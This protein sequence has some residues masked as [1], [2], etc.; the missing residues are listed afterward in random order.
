MRLYRTLLTNGASAAGPG[1][2]LTGHSFPARLLP[3]F[4]SSQQK[5]APSE[6][7]HT[8]NNTKLVLY[9]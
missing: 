5:R 8:L 6:P 4:L 7:P 3:S 2:L 9:K 1:K